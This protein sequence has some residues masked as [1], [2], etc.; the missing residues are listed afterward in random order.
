MAK[1]PTDIRSLARKHTATALNT[2]V[3]VASCK[4]ANESAQVAAATALLNRGWGM[5]KQTMELEGNP[6][7]VLYDRMTDQP[8]G[9]DPRAPAKPNGKANGH[10]NGSAE[11]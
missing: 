6:L 10:A 2:L 9:P 11:D 4:K 7:A 3:R 5:P 8:I 1:T